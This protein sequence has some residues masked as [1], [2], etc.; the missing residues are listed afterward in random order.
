[1][2]KRNPAK[3]NADAV[4]ESETPYAR[5]DNMLFASTLVV[6]GEARAFIV[7]IGQNTAVCR[8]QKMRR[9]SLTKNWIFYRL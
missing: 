3:K 7:E 2:G 5:Q 1:M 4:F 9:L 6:A 8:L